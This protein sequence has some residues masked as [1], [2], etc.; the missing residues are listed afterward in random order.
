MLIFNVICRRKNNN[1][2]A[3]SYTCRL[4]TIHLVKKSLNFTESERSSP[5]TQK[6]AIETVLFQIQ[7]LNSGCVCQLTSKMT[8]SKTEINKEHLS[9]A[10]GGTADPIT[11]Y[12]LP[13]T[14]GRAWN[15]LAVCT[16]MTSL[17]VVI[18]LF[19][20]FILLRFTLLFIDHDIQPKDLTKLTHV[21]E[22]FL[23]R[24]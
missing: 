13:Q 1:N 19:V 5:Y 22:S 18:I 8:E 14:K 20:P 9:C 10:G 15:H 4:Q 23:S 6:F 12:T 24:L 11:P 17:R 2:G 7:R 16:S 3:W 21:V